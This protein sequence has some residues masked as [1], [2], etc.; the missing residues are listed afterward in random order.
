MLR[1][2]TSPGSISA[3]PVC[4]TQS[5]TI[6]CE[7]LR[8]GKGTVFYCQPCDLGFLDGEK[9]DVRTFYESEYRESV[10]HR[11]ESSKTNAQEIFEVYEPFQGDRLELIGPYLDGK[12]ELLEI[13]A[14]AGQFISHVQD[15]CARIAAIE[16]DRDCVAFLNGKF[17]IET[18][19]EFLENSKFKND[20]FDVV[21]AFQVLEHTVD[22]VAFM[23]TVFDA[24]KLGG[25]AFIEMPNLYDPLLALWEVPAY[26]SFYYHAEHLFYFSAKS[27]QDV[28]ARAGFDPSRMKVHFLQ[29]YNVL[30]HLHWLMNNAPQPTNK[31]GL[32]PVAI[33]GGDVEMSSWLTQRM[34]A[35]NDE[36]MVKLKE[37][38]ATSNLMIELVR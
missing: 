34:S 19:G 14:S 22:P 20:Q 16:L 35:L 12:T 6:L 9:F 4:G 11:M 29:D 3:C 1:H 10:S 18:D 37:R 8:R 27:L 15:Q 24:T 32:S 25:R 33:T 21:C 5:E 17:D 30:N 13:G 31:V 28:C 38:G 26:Q 7:T 2:H 23:K 36:Y